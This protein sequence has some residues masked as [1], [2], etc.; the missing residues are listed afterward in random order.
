MNI[1][2]AV[3][4]TFLTKGIEIEQVPNKHMSKFLKRI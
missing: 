1:H 2:E 3:R 4:K